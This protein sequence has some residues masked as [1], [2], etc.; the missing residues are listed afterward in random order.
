MS[1]PSLS[2]YDT[3]PLPSLPQGD[4]WGSE[5]ILQSVSALYTAALEHFYLS[6]QT[7]HEIGKIYEKV[8]AYQCQIKSMQRQERESQTSVVDLMRRYSENNL[9]SVGVQQCSSHRPLKRKQEALFKQ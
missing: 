2:G 7:L 6:S 3:Q 8:I 5:E 1:I 4:V 9:L